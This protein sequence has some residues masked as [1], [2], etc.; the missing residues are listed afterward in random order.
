MVG[1]INK[2]KNL[3]A[4]F[5]CSLL[6]LYNFFRDFYM[7]NM[8][9]ILM[10][11]DLFFFMYICI[12]TV[13]LQSYSLLIILL[14]LFITSINL[15]YIVLF[16]LPTYI[17][18]INYNYRGII[19]KKKLKYI[20]NFFKEYYI[21]VILV[22][23]LVFSL[24]IFIDIVFYTKLGLFHLSL[25]LLLDPLISS[26]NLNKL[27]CSIKWCCRRYG[28][29]NT[30]S[31]ILVVFG[32]IYISVVIDKIF[33]EAAIEL[34]VYLTLIYAIYRFVFSAFI[35]SIATKLLV[36]TILILVKITEKPLN[37]ITTKFN[38]LKSKIYEFFYEHGGLS[39]L[40]LY[41][42]IVTN[43]IFHVIVGF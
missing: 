27:W 25:I 36:N 37:Y 14:D 43:I 6:L 13:F 7:I 10:L 31:S 40:V 39:I 11:F 35:T 30:L 26:I 16:L 22:G 33:A 1:L 4:C 23:S 38:P 18:I 29:L 17:K 2:V 9:I 15:N 12:N 28:I 21:I 3:Y 20:I 32:L 34:T 8:L 41:S 19:T 42:I 5:K 24:Y